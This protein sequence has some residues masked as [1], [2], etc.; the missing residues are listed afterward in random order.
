MGVF[1]SDRGNDIQLENEMRFFTLAIII[2][3]V[4]LAG[5]LPACAAPQQLP[6]E[7]VIG[8]AMPTSSGPA[9]GPN[10]IKA[11]ELAVSE[12]NSKGGLDGKKLL[13]KV[14]DEG[15]TAATA[16]YAV[17]KLVE[18][19]QAQVIIGGTSSDAVQ[20]IGPYVESKGVL[21][22]SHS[23]TSTSLSDQGWS[24]WVYSV[25]PLDSLQGGV[26]AKLI[27]DRGCKRV[28][29]LVQ[30]SIY[31]K[32]IEESTRRYLTGAAEVVASVKYDPQKL[33]Y[34]TELNSIKDKVPGCVVHAGYHTDG[35]VIF[36]QAAQSGLDNIGWITADGTYDLPLDKYID[37]A[38]FME[39]AVTG[40]VPSADRESDMYRAFTANYRSKYGFDPTSYCEN[41]YDAL[42]MIAAA[43]RQAGTYNG[44]AI[45]DALALVGKD[46]QGVSGTISFDQNGERIAG[47]YAVWKVAVEGT[48]YKYAMTGQYV[49]FLKSR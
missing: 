19:N 15:P 5:L 2:A 17:H 24:K 18:E 49:H 10:I 20:T 28:A 3:A 13:L 45:R 37:A 7:I 29:M 48:Q 32:D 8:C 31:G 25:A 44:S 23:A 21:L 12:L 46:Y 40:T 6:D 41:A 39:K 16:L 22:V 33:S 4:A 14:V 30:D 47:T 42:N 9:W 26:I 34:L 36:A 43:I 1:P 27:K 38:R 35:A 11:V